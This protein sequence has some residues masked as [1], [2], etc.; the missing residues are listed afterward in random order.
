MSSP[1]PQA[2]WDLQLDR[3]EHQLIEVGEFVA[4]A[5]DADKARELGL[6]NAASALGWK[7]TKRC[8]SMEVTLLSPWRVRN[9]QLSS[10]KRI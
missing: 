9:Y 8:S 3:T 10:G 5:W 6:T 2:R 7:C 1:N 4:A